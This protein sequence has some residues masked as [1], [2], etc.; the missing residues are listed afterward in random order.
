MEIVD[1]MY[2]IYNISSRGISPSSLLIVS[3]ILSPTSI[4]IPRPHQAFAQN[5]EVHIA[6]LQANGPI[7]ALNHKEVNGTL[8]I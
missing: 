7:Q 2:N 1:S 6:N 3:L 4:G 5:L 8:N